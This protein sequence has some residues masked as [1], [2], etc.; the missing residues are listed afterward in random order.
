M[1]PDAERRNRPEPAE[2]I[3]TKK[4]WVRM[5]NPNPAPSPGIVIEVGGADPNYL[6]TATLLATIAGPPAASG[7]MKW[8]DRVR[9][10]SRVILHDQRRLNA[11]AYERPALCVPADFDF[12]LDRAERLV[13][14]SFRQIDIAMG[15]A[16][17]QMPALVR[18]VA[19]ADGH[20]PSSLPRRWREVRSLKYETERVLTHEAE[21]GKF[22]AGRGEKLPQRFPAID[23][24]EAPANFRNRVVA[25]FRR[26]LHLAAGLAQ[27][28]DAA[29]RGLVE[30]AG[31]DGVDWT[32]RGLGVYPGGRPR[33]LRDRLLLVPEIAIVAIN[34]AYDLEAGLP[35]LDAQ[36]PYPATVVRFRWRPSSSESAA[37]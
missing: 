28:V 29:E 3:E 11:D 7:E 13:G 26:V 32:A 18:G 23:S 31:A 8:R 36:R 15:A 33:L 1:R 12:P 9:A 16:H 4:G 2:I 27:A 21:L 34:K 17:A 5:T 35:Y 22:L 14:S 6:I 24:A 10:F 20:P 19:L 25:P 30:I 37:A